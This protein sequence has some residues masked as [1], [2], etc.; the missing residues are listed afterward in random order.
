[1]GIIRLSRR[2]SNILVKKDNRLF[3]NNKFVESYGVKGIIRNYY[4][5][6]YG[7]EGMF[8]DKELFFST[9]SICM[10]IGKGV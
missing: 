9:M 8:S 3:V 2:F 5:S 7:M 1:M 6:V 4:T 10:W